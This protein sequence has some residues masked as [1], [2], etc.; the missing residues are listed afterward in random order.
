MPGTG[1]P[2]RSITPAR[3]KAIVG[4]SR[5]EATRLKRLSFVFLAFEGRLLAIQELRT[6]IERRN[7]FFAERPELTP[8][9]RPNVIFEAGLAMAKFR[10]STILVRVGEIRPFTDVA[11][12]HLLDLNN[13]VKTRTPFAKRLESCGLKVNFHDSYWQT[14]GDFTISQPKRYAARGIR[15]KDR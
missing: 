8:Q 1:T 3:K 7:Q 13:E 11:G 12:V 5:V 2:R 6:Y 15:S 4:K 10:D 9:P 14:A